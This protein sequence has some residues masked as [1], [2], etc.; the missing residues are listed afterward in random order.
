MIY[1]VFLVQP[2]DSYPVI[3]FTTERQ[4]QNYVQEH[5]CPCCDYY[6]KEIQIGG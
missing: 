3:A 2:L 4:A 5:K 6:Y 1:V